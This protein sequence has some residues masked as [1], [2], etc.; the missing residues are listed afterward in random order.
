MW[1]ELCQE[2]SSKSSH[3][4]EITRL[5]LHNKNIHTVTLVV[6]EE[7][8]NSPVLA[9]SKGCPSL[10]FHTSSRYNG[11]CL[12]GHFGFLCFLVFFFALR[13]HVASATLRD[14]QYGEIKASRREQAGKKGLYVSVRADKSLKIQLALRIRGRGRPHG[15]NVRKYPPRTQHLH[16]WLLIHQH[17]N[18]KLIFCS[19]GLY[20]V[21]FLPTSAF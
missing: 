18:P 1:A 14:K 2:T 20:L 13:F 7:T 15:N 8:K 3:F 12:S 10:F 17:V 9:F 19:S 21:C 6:L 4:A 16:S 11:F 5:V